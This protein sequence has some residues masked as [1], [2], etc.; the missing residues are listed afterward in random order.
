M[1]KREYN[2]GYNDEPDMSDSLLDTAAKIVGEYYQRGDILIF[3]PGM[4]E[5]KKLSDWLDNFKSKCNVIELHSQYSETA[6]EQLFSRDGRA[7]VIISTNIAESS[8][9]LPDCKT[10]IDFCM[11]KQNNYDERTRFQRLELKWASHASLTQRAGRVGRVSDG[12]V[13]RL[14]PR[15][16][17][18]RFAPY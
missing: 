11:S 4:R 3:V 8:I 12:M 16:H 7:K 14:I 10:V 1:K 6:Y 9:T 15:G 18:D 17:M 2:S 13:F 5:I